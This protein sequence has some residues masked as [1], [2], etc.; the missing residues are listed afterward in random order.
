M[1]KTGDRI[2]QLR[3]ISKERDSGRLFA[4]PFYHRH[5]KLSKIVPGIVKGILYKI[6]AQSGVGKTQLTKDLFCITP[7]EYLR[8]NPDTNLKVKIFYFALEESEEEFIDS[9][10]CNRL[11]TKHGIRVDAIMLRGLKED[12]ANEEILKKI[13][14]CEADVDFYMEHIE[15]VDSVYNPTG[16]YKYC[17]SYSEKVGTHHWETKTFVKN[18]VAT[19][20]KVYSHYVQDD[21]DLHVICIADH[22]SLIY[23]E[24]EKKLDKVLSK[25][26]AM[27]KWST[28]YC[29]KQISKHWGW[30][31]VNVQQQEQ[32]KEK[33]HYTNTGESVVEK[34][35]PSLDGLA[36]NKE[37]QRDDYVILSVYSPDKFGFNEYHGYD[38]DRFRDTFRAVK[39][40]KN[41]IGSPNGYVHFVFDGA[42]N[43]F[44]E[45]PRVGE[46][47]EKLKTAYAT[48]DRLLGR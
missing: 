2:K 37:L 17:R 40:L 24:Y 32:S 22:I 33:Q 15:V 8:A 11:A 38:I 26:E 21:P 3:E 4:I 12:Y 31:V 19:D 13:E 10:I 34:T 30:T 35:E 39:V 27:A 14:D 43:R 47:P 44:V 5:P 25:H 45:L 1:G 36:N 6:T 28:E 42:T 18:G 20:E 46:D 29:K 41:R 48:A 23:P 16:M 9:L 7:L